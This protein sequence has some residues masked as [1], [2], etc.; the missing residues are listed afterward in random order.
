V[1]R[2]DYIPKSLLTPDGVSL[3]IRNAHATPDSYSERNGISFKIN[4][5]TFQKLKTYQ[6][7]ILGIKPN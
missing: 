5:P 7:W 3:S 6:N 2:R 1:G 4:K